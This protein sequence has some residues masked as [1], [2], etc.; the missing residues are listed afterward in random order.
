MRHSDLLWK[1]GYLRLS[2]MLYSRRKVWILAW[3]LGQIA[4]MTSIGLLALSGWFLTAAGLTGILSLSTAYTFDYFTPAGIIRLLAISR[5]VGRY[6]ERL[7]S[8]NAVLGLLADLRSSMFARLAEV[9]QQK[10]ASI[11]QMHRLISDID[12]LNVWP[13][14]VVL[15]GLWVVV[16]LICITLWSLYVGGF[17]LAGMVFI[18]LFCAA[19]IIP[20]LG[21]RYG[22]QLA[23]LQT[24]QVER[25][26]EALLHPLVAL[27][28]LLQWQQW[29]RFANKFH[30]QDQHYVNSQLQQ[31]KLAGKIMLLQHIFLALTAILLLWQGSQ[32]LITKHITAAMLLALLL[33]VLG[34]TELVVVLGR[35]I[36]AFGLCQAA[37]SRLN[38]LVDTE[39]VR[40]INKTILP[41]EIHIQAE[42]LYARW[43]DA[44]NGAENI[45]FNITNGDILFI[46]GPSGVGKSTLLSVLAN[47]LPPSAGTLKC[48]NRPFS[49]W[50]WQGQIAYLSQQLDIFDLSLAENLRLGKAQASEEE[51]WIVLEQVKLAEWARTQPQGLN[52]R[53]GEYGAAI[54]GGQARR[55]ALARFLLRPYTLMIL[56]EPFAGL[57]ENTSAHIAKMLQIK[58]QQGIL[59]VASHQTN[60]WLQA[61][62]LSLI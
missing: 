21:G 18:P 38:E 26:R 36:L 59:I 17:I 45:N 12:L 51:L 24:Q 22:Y 60:P 33:M 54:S 50:Q 34:F 25:R 53:L 2:A 5:T 16:V 20:V 62:I 23:L 39:N 10:S 35:N 28:A 52:T 56:D 14:N 42:N 4:A 13:L 3:L 15:P 8:H 44:L 31:Q 61:R 7:V 46:S 6:G 30:I 49:Y 11:R 47:E 29:T 48:N 37:C 43:P 19:A 1:D 27:T 57:D 41:E 58:Q 55:I 40:S 9:E 32:L